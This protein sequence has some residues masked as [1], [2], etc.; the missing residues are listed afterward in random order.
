MHKLDNLPDT[1]NVP[2]IRALLGIGLRQTYQLV[3]TKPFEKIRI[4]NSNRYSKKV[5]RMWL[6][7]NLENIN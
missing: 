2:E 3:K 1:L 5:L 6:E 4:G 7:G